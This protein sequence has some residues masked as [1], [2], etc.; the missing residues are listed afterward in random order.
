MLQADSITPRRDARGGAAREVR[1]PGDGSPDLLKPQLDN[2]AE[3]V[4]LLRVGTWI[5]VA[6]L[7]AYFAASLYAAGAYAPI[8]A[9]LP[10]VAAAA[11]F[12]ALTRM[13]TFPAWRKP[14]TL[15]FTL[16]VMAT[17]FAIAADI[18]EPEL[19][20]VAALLVPL[21][22]ASFGGWSGGWQA[23]TN[24]L[25]LL[26]FASV[27][28]F[29][30]AGKP[31]GVY[32]WLGLLAALALAQ[33]TAI[34]LDRYR[35]N[36]RAQVKA[37]QNAAEFR[38]RQTA[39]MAHDIRNPLGALAGF[40]GMLEDGRLSEKERAELLGRIGSIARRM[41]LLV[42]NV[43]DLVRLEE[44][45]LR[46]SLR[47]ANPDAIVSDV[48]NGYRTEMQRKGVALVTNLGCGSQANLDPLHLERT[49]ANLLANAIARAPAGG[50]IRVNS[51]L[52][53]GRFR[54]EVIDSGGRLDDSEIA[55]LFDPPDSAANHSANPSR[56]GLFVARALVELGGGRLAASSSSGSG[57][58]LLAEIPAEPVERKAP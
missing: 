11:I 52:A 51:A 1:Q 40:A 17:F 39:M 53:D 31:A 5:L 32:Q 45:R 38:D 58:T 37:L 16:V 25:F 2:N 42:G 33:F 13:P 26:A 22:V 9:E 19:R 34:F 47:V 29:A 49:A 43:V 48:A 35:R 20:Y 36:L 18:H 27:E 55:E 3:A 12:L 8:T 4:R 15:L 24:T 23:A 7:L 46:A 41:D 21:S 6:F 10:A 56:L 57:L 28:L 44:G 54:L 50:E 30:P 14:A